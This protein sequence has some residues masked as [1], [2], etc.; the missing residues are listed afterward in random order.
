MGNFF[1]ILCLIV[2]GG[3]FFIVFDTLRYLWGV[4]KTTGKWFA[5][6]IDSEI[7]AIT[8]VFLLLG[9]VVMLVGLGVL[10]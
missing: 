7:F 9:I 4:R 1:N 3:C 8:A 10:L 6:H 2:A 5:H